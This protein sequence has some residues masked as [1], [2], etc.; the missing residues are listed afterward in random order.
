MS[1][2]ETDLF[3]IGELAR[4]VGATPRAVRYY[5]ELGLLV[6]HGRPEGSHRLYGSHDEARLRELLRIRD[7]LGLSL[8]ELREWVDAE[9][10]RAQL[11][12][13]WNEDETITSAERIAIMT[14]ALGHL[15]TQLSVVRARR[16]AL[17][18]LEDGL[19]SHRRRVRALLAE[20]EA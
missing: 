2:T 16:E 18:E 14:E 17:E 7:L 3:R 20:F 1:T 10:R 15:E 5:E 6:G 19:V 4:R 12:A 8:G 9:T 13:R 11:R